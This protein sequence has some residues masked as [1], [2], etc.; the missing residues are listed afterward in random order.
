MLANASELFARL[1]A[2]EAPDVVL[3]DYLAGDGRLRG[4]DLV[5]ALRAVAEST[6]I[7]ATAER[8]DVTTAAEAVQAGATD[9]LVR[10]EPLEER[11]VT[12][13]GK[14]SPTMR[15][16]A[17]NRELRDQSE[18]LGAE[19]RARSRIIGD[20][21]QIVELLR[22][23]RRVARVPRPVLITGERGTGKELVARA[24]HEASDRAERPLITVNCAAYPDTLLESEL[25]GHERGAFTG[26]DRLV[27]GKF[28]LADGGTLF[29]DEIGAMSVAFQSKILRVVEYGTFTRVGGGTELK[30]RAR[31]LAATNANLEE[32]MA[33]GAFL[34]DLYDRLSFEVI[35]VPALR[36]R[37][38]DVEV[39]AH[40]F[41]SQFM[42]EI[43]AFH[44]KHL[45]PAAVDA[46]K[47]HPFPGNVRELKN[48]IE[49]AAYRET[50]SEI[51]PEE[52]GLSATGASTE[53]GGTGDFEG[54]VRAFK[55]RLLTEALRAAR[56]NQAEAARRL[57]LSYHQFR[58][59]HA[60]LL[61]KGDAD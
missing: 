15:L 52:L 40:H 36:E 10:S 44:G 48:V 53:G 61:G 24:I 45:S 42:R 32:L 35:Q 11:V 50:E 26:A 14:L 28:E 31:L 16:L 43:P 12:L 23:L 55:V 60:R 30:T 6:P 58:Y 51:G 4:G 57:G 54:S 3:V 22:R 5:R 37:A 59:H 47:R 7:V 39:L 20:S 41:L 49:R 34:R 33:R 21:P 27:R 29:L 17:E 38:G 9:F 19:L 2:S 1:T 56:G 46:L 13:L 25:F 8:G 18:Q